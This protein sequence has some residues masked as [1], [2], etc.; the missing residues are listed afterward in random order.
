MGKGQAS[1]LEH[2]FTVLLGVIM[3][4][5][6]TSLVY[7][8]YK[9]AIE[10]EAAAQ[11]RQIAIQVSENIVKLHQT[12]RGSTSS[13]KNYTSVFIG[14]VDLNLPDNVAKR[15]YEVSFVSGSTLWSQVDVLSVDGKNVSF[16][17]NVSSAKVVAR[18]T[19]DPRVSVEIDVP[20]IDATLQGKISNGV[21]D[22]ISYYRFN[23]NNTLYDK[24]ILGKAD[25]LSVVE[26]VS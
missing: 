8:F 24:V 22:K 4:V 14:D 25:M 1:I 13:P 21:D 12:S 19:Q 10:N 9:N 23:V 6:I 17:R 3:I 20:N 15:N 11:L 16:L 7:G 5:A 18:T 26:G 2:V